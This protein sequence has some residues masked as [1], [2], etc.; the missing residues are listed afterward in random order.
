MVSTSG[1]AFLLGD[2]TLCGGGVLLIFRK[3]SSVSGV[4]DH[5]GTCTSL[6]KGCILIAKR[7]SYFC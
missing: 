5:T 6:E 2:T 3:G 4:E 1:G 7:G